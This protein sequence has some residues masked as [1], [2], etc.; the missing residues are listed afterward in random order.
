MSRTEAGKPRQAIRALGVAAA[1]KV[2]E[3]I[4]YGHPTELE[5]EVLAFLRGALVREAP[6][7]GARANLMRIGDRGIIGVAEGLGPEE[8][9]WAIAHELGH[10]EAHS[11]ISFLGL[12]EAE[13]M[14]PSYRASGRE[15]EANA[16]AAELLMPEDLFAPGCDVARVSWTPVR[17]L[18]ERFAVSATAAAL[19][20]VAFTDERVA[21]VCMKDG[22]VEWSSASKEFGPK[23]RRGSKVAEWTE[24][25]DF[26]AKGSAPSARRRSRRAPGST[27][28]R[29]TRSSLVEH[30]L[31]IRR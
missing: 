3:A 20:F 30:V 2:R 12:C 9:R 22:R 7:R 16:F 27:R 25:H 17:K 23:P 11:G 13:D 15:P 19:R 26:F 24:A 14:I 5:I 1:R 6:T 28:G 10:F 31:T 4:G 21:V 8:R 29:T 18:A